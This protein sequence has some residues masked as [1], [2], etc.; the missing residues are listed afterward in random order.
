[1]KES[2]NIGNATSNAISPTISLST[3][4]TSLLKNTMPG[5]D[6]GNPT[7]LVATNQLIFFVARDGDFSGD[8]RLWATD[9]TTGG[10]YRVFASHDDI[11]EDELD[12]YDFQ[13]TALESSVIF[14]TP[15]EDEETVGIFV[16]NGT[17]AGTFLLASF[18]D[19]EELET[20]SDN[21][22]HFYGEKSD[23]GAEPWI[24]DGTLDGTALL[25]DFNPSTSSFPITSTGASC[26]RA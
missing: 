4:T 16:S 14:A 10:T 24:T 9:G 17:A 23:T 25:H 12:S 13:M 20:R 5:D 11:A 18:D 15:Q 6:N 1:M 3:D 26:K 21:K 2:R 8:G 22:A 19:V 7:D